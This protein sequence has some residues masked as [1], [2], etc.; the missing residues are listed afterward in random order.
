VSGGG[1]VIATA[2]G[3]KLKIPAGPAGVYRLAQ[4][5]N[6]SGLRRDDF[7]IHAPVRLSLRARISPDTCTGTW[8]FGLWNDPFALALNP[9]RRRL[10]LPASPRTTWFL[11]ASTASYLSLHDDVPANGMMAQVFSGARTRQWLPRVAFSLLFNRAAARAMLRQYVVEESR[12]IQADLQSWHDYEIRWGALGVHY[13]VD[14]QTLLATSVVPQPPLGLVIWIDNQFA[15]F[16]PAGRLGWG[17]EHSDADSS[18]EISGL[19][20]SQEG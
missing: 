5:D 1:E 2:T 6:Y 19:R 8:G 18:L 3:W 15:A 17:F 20:L 12:L 7:P 4:I 14:E 11:W 9:F 16:D 13:L 10:L